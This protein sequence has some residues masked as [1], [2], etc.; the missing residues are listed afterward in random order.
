MKPTQHHSNTR[1]LN[2]P[3][4]WDQS[5]LPVGALPITDTVQAGVPTVLSFWRPDAEDLALLNA[6]GLICLSVVGRNMPPVSILAWNEPPAAK[7][8]GGDLARLAGI[9]CNDPAFQAW[10]G[11]TDTQTARRKLCLKCGIESRAELD[12]N[13]RAAQYFH[14]VIRE[15]YRLHLKAQGAAS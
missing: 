6:G 10:I 5:Q 1:T 2:A 15:P 14:A 12:H 9:W 7:P 4:G 3:A 11:A 8:K 13:P